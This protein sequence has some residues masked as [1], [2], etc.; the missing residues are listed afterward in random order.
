[1]QNNFFVLLNIFNCKMNYICLFNKIRNQKNKI[2]N[3]NGHDTSRFF[4][5]I[6]FKKKYLYNYSDK[7][8]LKL[9]MLK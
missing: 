5:K 3:K 6:G 7:R 2:Y 8:L 1:M 4:Y 9:F